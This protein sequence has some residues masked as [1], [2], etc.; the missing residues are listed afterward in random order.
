MKIKN[1]LKFRIRNSLG[2]FFW[3]YKD[4]E[5]FFFNV[6]HLQKMR[7]YGRYTPNVFYFIIDP[8][9]NHPGLADRLKAIVHCYNT[10]KI[11]GLNFKIVYKVPFTL[12]QY[13][14]PNK[15]DWVASYKDIGNDMRH[16]KLYNETNW[17]TNDSKLKKGKEYDCFN[18]IGNLLPEAFD[19][20][21]YK[22][23]DLFH[24]LFKPCNE[25]TIMMQS[26]EM[27]PPDSYV[28][29]HFRFVNALEHF[30]DG[31]Y[32]ELS[33]QEKGNLVKRCRNVLM[34]IYA[35]N[36]GNG[37]FVFSD[38]KV[39]LDAIQDLPVKTLSDSNIGHIS[40]NNS[41]NIVLKTFLDL[42]MISRS[43]KVYIIHAP[44]LYNSSGFA[45]VGARIG[46]KPYEIINA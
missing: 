39:F 11:N 31:Y 20:S 41:N 15:I 40:F 3:Y 34:D 22:W 8:N 25:L 36:A 32:N 14:L 29:V 17:H 35:N 33:K 2:R 16:I 18:Y 9:K 7:L 4:I 46:N 19:D 13:L 28:A 27:P 21:G 12:E 30:E 5:Y 1:L 45:M 6:L 42:F 43:S 24:E 23:C 44:E 10:A 38:S 26:T 37:V